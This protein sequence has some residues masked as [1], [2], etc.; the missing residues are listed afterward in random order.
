[1]INPLYPVVAALLIHGAASMNT[2]TSNWTTAES[3]RW[4][5]AS[6]WRS[7]RNLTAHWNGTWN[8]NW[9]RNDNSSMTWNSTGSIWTNSTNATMP[10]TNSTTSSVNSTTPL[11]NNS[12]FTNGTTLNASNS[13]TSNANNGTTSNATQPVPPP[14]PPVIVI[15]PT[16]ISAPNSKADTSPQNSGSGL[17]ANQLLGIWIGVAFA[18]AIAGIYAFVMRRQYLKKLEDHNKF[19]TLG[20]SHKG[21]PGKTGFTKGSVDRQKSLSDRSSTHTL[22]SSSGDSALEIDLG[23]TVSLQEVVL[24]KMASMTSEPLQIGKSD[25]LRSNVSEADSVISVYHVEQPGDVLAYS[26]LVVHP[27]RYSTASHLSNATEKT[28]VAD[29]HDNYVRKGFEI[30]P[31][32]RL[33]APEPA[34]TTENSEIL[35]F[36]FDE[37]KLDLS[38]KQEPVYSASGL[39]AAYTGHHDY[40]LAYPDPVL[41]SDNRSTLFDF[42]FNGT[43]SYLDLSFENSTEDETAMQES[44]VQ[45]TTEAHSREQEPNAIITQSKEL[46]EEERISR[47][48][49]EKQKKLSTGNF[50]PLAVKV[51]FSSAKK[52][53][54]PPMSPNSPQNYDFSYYDFE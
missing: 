39:T 13:T 7:H 20:S 52:A 37:T 1:M 28:I 23:E 26:R 11:Q 47:I 15:A 2:S 33:S 45:R 27:T 8:W 51:L 5:Y 19:S 54:Q 40:E 17:Q 32:Y 38:L 46:T 42:D 30:I 36:K 21:D 18:A 3:K 50:S 29:H 12:T 14:S 9:T 44:N 35:D 48:T 6:G 24:N 22:V 41:V 16:N 10:S 43:D 49:A 25:T 34:Y 31:I 4:K 53:G